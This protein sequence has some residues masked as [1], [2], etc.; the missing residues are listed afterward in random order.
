M[1]SL[2]KKLNYR[3]QLRIAVINA[4]ENFLT[5]LLQEMPGVQIDS[6]IDQRYPYTFIIAF[7][8]NIPDVRQL[9][10]LILH[11]LATDGVLW[12]CYPK[13][14]PGKNSTELNRD[15]GWKPLNDAGFFVIRNVAVDDTWSALRFRNIRF[16]KS[17]SERFKMV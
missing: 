14:K 1:T 6:D 4:E 8:R 3:E 5:A 16:I 10:P 13:K 17:T 15:N 9:T 2:L 11:N 7:V 12:F